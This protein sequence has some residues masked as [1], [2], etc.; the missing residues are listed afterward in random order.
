MFVV[1]MECAVDELQYVLCCSMMETLTYDVIFVVV[2][3]LF[4]GD[5]TK[6]CDVAYAG[7]VMFSIAVYV[8]FENVKCAS[9]RIQFVFC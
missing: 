3:L 9:V 5:L 6:F 4:D 8:L 7:V 2:G 1:S